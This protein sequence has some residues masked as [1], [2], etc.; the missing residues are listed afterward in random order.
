MLNLATLMAQPVIDGLLYGATYALAALG[1]SLIFSVLGVLNLAHG[2]FVM[3][4]GFVGFYFGGIFSVSRYG[5]TAV[6][7]ILLVSFVLIAILG[8][9]YEFAFIKYV[10]NR[11]STEVLISSILVTI[12]TAF[13][14]ENVGYQYMPL[15]IPFRQTI[16][17]ILAPVSQLTISY[18]GIFVD[19]VKVIALITLAVS[20][21]LLY[22]FSRR[23]Y[24]G[25]AMRAI[26]QNRESTL[27]MGVNLQRVSI[28][29][30]AIGSGFGALAGVTIAMTST[31]SPGFGIAY[32]ISLLSVMVLGGTRSYW[33]PLVG[34]LIIGLLQTMVQSQLVNSIY[35]PLVDV[36]FNGI[37]YWAPAISIVVLILVLL[38]R[39]TGLAG[40]R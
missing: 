18:G 34:G 19:G 5:L 14:I 1:L 29:T 25:K 40:R 21:V 22:L 27:L 39:P 13:I 24:L 10:L 17:R 4:G 20:T 28:M 38:I 26:T 15:F 33:G 11:T 12:G 32:T 2:D 31:M 36:S 30:F 8:A 7:G 6:L 23:T 9:A 35:I 37:Y 16:F 3:L